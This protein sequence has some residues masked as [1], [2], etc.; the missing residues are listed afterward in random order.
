MNNEESVRF[1]R[2]I[3]IVSLGMADAL[4]AG[5]I[6][7]DEAEKLLFSPSTLHYLKQIV[8][9]AHIIRLVSAGMELEDVRELASFD[10]WLAAVER[11]RAD[12]CEFLGETPR[13]NSQLDGWVPRF[14]QAIV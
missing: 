13:V 14:V 3:A 1:Q 7:G 12:A 2:L 8:A 6:S 4:I 5:A 10:A 9:D 11:I